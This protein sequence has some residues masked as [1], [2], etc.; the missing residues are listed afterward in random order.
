M[1]IQRISWIPLVI[2]VFIYWICE[3]IFVSLAIGGIGFCLMIIRLNGRMEFRNIRSMKWS[4]GF[5][6]F[7][8][9][10]HLLS[11]FSTSFIEEEHQFWFYFLSTY[12]LLITIEEKSLNNFLV[13]ALCRLI[14]S[15]NQTGNKWL[16][17]QD[18]GDF[19]NT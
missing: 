2:P 4:E 15:W 7:Y 11:L 13:F 1:D 16:H 18:I 14:R 9:L 10:F 3:E 8:P 12:F 19:L 17:L 6:M 5:L